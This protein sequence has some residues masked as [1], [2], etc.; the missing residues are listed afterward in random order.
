MAKISDEMFSENFMDEC[1][2][3]CFL[4]TSDEDI[5][6]ELKSHQNRYENRELIDQGGMKKIISCYDRITDREIARANKLKEE[7][8]YIEFLQEARITAKLEHPNIV[9]IY[10]I[11]YEEGQIFF[12]MKKLSGENLQAIID[13]LAVNDEETCKKFPRSVLLEIFL[14]ACDAISFAHSKKILHL[15]IKPA[16]IQ[17]DEYGQVLVCDWGLAR[18]ASSEIMLTENTDFNEVFSLD[19]SNNNRIVG[20]PGYMAP[21]QI[22]RSFGK[23]GPCSDIFSVGALLYTMLTYKRPIHGSEVKDI[24][25]NTSSGNWIEPQKRVS[26]AIPGALN[27]IVM[28]AM[29][30]KPEKRYESV[31]NLAADMRSYQN[32][33]AT[34][35]E[36]AGFFRQC[37]LLIIRHKKIA[38]VST[39][40][41]FILMLT[42]ISFIHRLQQEKNIALFSQKEESQ[43][44]LKAENAEQQA[45][46]L[47]EKLKLKQELVLETRREAA[48]ELMKTSFL[49]TL[50]QRKYHASLSIMLNI[51][52]LDP[53]FQEAIYYHGKLR[54]G[55]LHYR[56]AHQILSSYR[57]ERNVLWI[58]EACLKFK[59]EKGEWDKKLDWHKVLQLKKDVISKVSHDDS[60]GLLRQMTYRLTVIL[61]MNEQLAFARRSMELRSSGSITFD[62][63]RMKQ[64]YS[65][66]LKG[67]KI[68][69]FD[70]INNLKLAELDLSDTNIRDLFLL[71][72]MKL[73]SLNIANT[74]VISLKFLDT[75][76][77]Q[78]LDM[79]GTK[80]DSLKLINASPL[81][82]LW[83]NK[84]IMDLKVLKSLENLKTL[85]IPRGVYD[86]QVI[87]SLIPQVE[88]IRE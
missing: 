14:K 10:D 79:R 25:L 84:F 30:L 52:E 43:M 85:V 9:P 15:D 82:K 8:G 63:Q 83:L 6:A 41:L 24:I 2:E 68:A 37:R 70:E 55:S 20:T 36:E 60:W 40:S 61:S 86:L 39:F 75:S 76:Q 11:G 59:N 34:E 23:R 50:M 81:Q 49:P 53:D 13:R 66:S 7:P 5:I 33:F 21:E 78:E 31:H 54:F 77:L 45:L 73:I 67:N 80:I 19:L 38:L 17:V 64:G 32:G 56:E 29:A 46:T 22:N 88:I 47:I 71:R 65:L 27:S 1:L 69:P 26:F 16:N 4:E 18:D 28:K 42:T 3:D 74:P 35:A 44:R 12:I 57:G 51:R 62:L 87:Q 48:R 58:L 72:K